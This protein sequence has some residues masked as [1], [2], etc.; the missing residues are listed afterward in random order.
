MASKGNPQGLAL[1]LAN[2]HLLLEHDL[3]LD[4]HIV[5]GLNVLERRRLV[6]RL[7][8]EVVV[9]HLDVAQLLHLEHPA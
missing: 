4:G 3:A 6:A 9:L 2:L 7:A 8:L 1:A 5:L